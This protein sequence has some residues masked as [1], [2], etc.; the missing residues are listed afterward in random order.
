MLALFA[1]GIAGRVVHIKSTSEFPGDTGPAIGA[2]DGVDARHDSRSVYLPDVIE[3]FPESLNAAVYRL[4]VLDELGFHE[5]GTYRFDIQTAR[6]QVPGLPM[7]ESN[8]LGL[9][10]SD[11]NL[12][13][14]CF[15][16]PALAQI[17]F[18]VIETARIQAAVARRYPGTGRYREALRQHFEAHWQDPSGAMSEVA[19]LRG[20]LFGVD[21][22]SRLFPF[23]V[24]VLAP[25]ANVYTSANA[26]V[27]CIGS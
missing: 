23:A 20:A 18:R 12:F 15:D 13:F 6:R 24:D 21:L 26:T 4:A 10:E 9:R 19:R 3:H 11:L 7:R 5:F 25:D 8:A 2:G 1:E 22:E 16:N 17:L 27:A 14:H